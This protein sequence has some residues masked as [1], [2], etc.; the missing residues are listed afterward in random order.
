MGIQNSGPPGW[1]GRCPDSRLE[2]RPIR[3]AISLNRIEFDLRAEVLHWFDRCRAKIGGYQDLLPALDPQGAQTM[4]NGVSCPEEIE[5]RSA[6]LPEPARNVNAVREKHGSAGPGA[7]PARVSVGSSIANS[8]RALA[9]GWGFASAWRSPWQREPIDGESTSGDKGFGCFESSATDSPSADR[10][11][12]NFEPSA[13]VEI[14]NDVFAKQK[15]R[16]I[17][18]SSLRRMQ[19]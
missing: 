17:D 13:C 3:R 16:R 15:C 10:K 5:A 18:A 14:P 7:G 8:M 12:H 4:K 11:T 9:G 19:S 1:H 6:D 2:I